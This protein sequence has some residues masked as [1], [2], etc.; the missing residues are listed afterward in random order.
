MEGDE[1][2]AKMTGYDPDGTAILIQKCVDPE[3]EEETA[4]RGS[5][6][7]SVRSFSIHRLEDCSKNEKENQ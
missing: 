3:V 7:E 2:T 4:R 6:Y 5:L 1:L